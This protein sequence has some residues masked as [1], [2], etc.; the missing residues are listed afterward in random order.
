MV[1]NGQSTGI[2]RL[3]LFRLSLAKKINLQCLFYHVV[4]LGSHL[5][6]QDLEI[7]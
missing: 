1:V 6:V 5:T 2:F 3:L 7:Q 4:E